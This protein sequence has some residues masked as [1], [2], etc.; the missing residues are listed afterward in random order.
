MS[1]DESRSLDGGKLP[2]ASIAVGEGDLD[3]EEEGLGLRVVV[4]LEVGGDGLDLLS[5]RC[6]TWSAM[7]AW[8]QQET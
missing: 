1:G 2:H 8:E 4:L 7:D 5:I 3:E 6:T